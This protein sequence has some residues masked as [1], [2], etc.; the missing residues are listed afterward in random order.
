MEEEHDVH[1]QDQQ[2][3]EMHDQ[4]FEEDLHLE[5]MEEF[6]EL[7][8]DV[9]ELP[10]LSPAILPAGQEGDEK[11]TEEADK[12]S[13]YVGNVDYAAT[14]EELQEHF[15]SCGGINRITI[16]I[17]KFSGTPKGYAYIEFCDDEGVHNAV[18]L[19]GSLFRGRQLKVCQKRTNTP[20]IK[21]K[22]KG[23]KGKVK[24]KG[25]YNGW[26]GPWRSKAKGKGKNKQVG[27]GYGAPY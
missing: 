17:D 18:M 24:G 20:G 2:Q 26:Y 12:R 15:K 9:E 14:P 1:Q 3:Q 6:E 8:R 22:G 21:G 19:N 25:K 16:L 23:K 27:K 13:V 5:H 7:D 11:N 10:S 4:H